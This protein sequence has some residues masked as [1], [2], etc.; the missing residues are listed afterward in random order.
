MPPIKTRF[1]QADLD[2]VRDFCAE[3]WPNALRRGQEER[4]PTIESVEDQDDSIEVGPFMITLVAGGMRPSLSVPE[5]MPFA[6][7]EVT[8]GNEDGDVIEVCRRDSLADALMAC[9]LEERRWDL[10]NGLDALAERQRMKEEQA[11]F[12]P[13]AG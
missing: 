5:G 2:Y 12:G 10:Q 3:V 8:H 4:L 1:T 6:Q 7:Y 9:A 13:S 11:L